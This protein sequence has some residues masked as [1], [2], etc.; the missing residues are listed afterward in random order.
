MLIDHET[1]MT[2]ERS[3]TCRA[4][5]PP[6]G[7]DA[8][9]K[10]PPA[11]PDTRAMTQ[12]ITRHSTPNRLRRGDSD[13]GYSFPEILVALVLMGTVMAAVMA[14]MFTAIKAS[15][16]SDDASDLDAVL[17][18]AAD[19]LNDA[20]FVACPE[21]TTPNAYEQFADVGADALGWD[22]STVR[23][24]DVL[25]WD[26]TTAPG[27]QRWLDSNGIGGAQCDSTVWLSSAK[28]MQKVVVEATTPSGSE[29]RRLEVVMTDI[30]PK[31]S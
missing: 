29:T 12:G 9:L 24:V 18:A 19:S 22:P 10:T 31:E 26:P 17:G 23:V 6:P 13:G 21:E 2:T 11:L 3:G 27:D 15:S 4:D 8:D 5:T 30:R 14:G 1:P 20:L 25:Y 16:I 28:T 7:V